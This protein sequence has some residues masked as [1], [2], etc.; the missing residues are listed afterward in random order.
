[1]WVAIDIA[2]A[3]NEVLIESPHGCRRHFRLANTLQDFAKLAAFLSSSGYS[4]HI[5]FEATADYHRPLAHFLGA[6]GFALSLVSSLA[7]ARTRDALY[8]SWDKN[9][10]KDAQVILHLLKT[11]ATQ[12]YHDPLANHYHDL[13][14]LANTY[15]QISL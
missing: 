1:M 2:K 6:Q 14:E 5:A 3:H 7:V 10:P 9:D 13:Q 4:C 12:V 15:Q 11:G 8:N